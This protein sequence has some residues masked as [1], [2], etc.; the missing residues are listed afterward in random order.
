MQAAP[1]PDPLIAPALLALLAFLLGGTAQVGA[2]DAM[3]ANRDGAAILG[4]WLTEP[5]DGIIEIT[6]TADGHFEGQIIG[7]NEP[8]KLDSKNPD[9]SLRGKPLR[10]QVIARAL[11]YDGAN[12]YSGGTIYDP[13]SG[14]TYKLRMELRDDGTLKVRGYIGISLLGKTQVWTRYTATTLDLPPPA[15]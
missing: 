4:R 13:A 9:A 15:R 2:A 1:R 14:S 11:A 7:G 5:R 12:K 6:R 10:G 3:P 8:G